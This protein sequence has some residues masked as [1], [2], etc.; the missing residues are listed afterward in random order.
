MTATRLTSYLLDEKVSANI[1]LQTPFF[2]STTETCSPFQYSNLICLQL[3]NYVQFYPMAILWPCSRL[4]SVAGVVA[5]VGTQEFFGAALR[6]QQ[7]LAR[8]LQGITLRLTS[9]ISVHSGYS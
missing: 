4:R 2:R 9:P 5:F 3:T 1:L 7:L 6:G 8:I